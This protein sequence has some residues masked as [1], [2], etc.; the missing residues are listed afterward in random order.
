MR[1]ITADIIKQRIHR[2]RNQLRAMF[3]QPFGGEN[4]GFQWMLALQPANNLLGDKLARFIAL[5]K[6]DQLCDQRIQ[7]HLMTIVFGHTLQ[8]QRTGAG[9][10]D[11][12]NRPMD[13]ALKQAL[14]TRIIG[15]F[16][17]TAHDLQQMLTNAAGVFWL[18][19]PVANQQRRFVTSNQC[20]QRLGIEKF[21]LHELAEIFANPVFITRDNRRMTRNDRNRHA[22]KQRHHRKPVRQRADH[23]RF[24]NRLHAAHPKIGR[25][26]QRNDKGSSGDKQ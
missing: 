20:H 12:I 9:K 10:I 26:K 18:A 11:L 17:K 2:V 19:K 15:K 25:Q 21:F 24:S 7:Q 4:F 22:A 1:T 6:G 3:A 23:R 5:E 13:R 14:N 8:H 16:E